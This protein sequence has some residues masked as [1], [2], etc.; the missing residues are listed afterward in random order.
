M[1]QMPP[2]PGNVPE[3]RIILNESTAAVAAGNARGSIPIRE[4]TWTLLGVQT[5]LIQ[6]GNAIQE[7]DLDY[8]LTYP[9]VGGSEIAIRRQSVVMAG[10][11]PHILRIEE[12]PL[13]GPGELHLAVSINASITTSGILGDSRLQVSVALIRNQSDRLNP[14]ESSYLDEYEGGDLTEYDAGILDV[15]GAAL[16]GAR[17]GA[18][19]TGRG[20]SGLLSSAIAGAGIGV[21][22]HLMRNSNVPGSSGLALDALDET[23]ND[24]APGQMDFDR[25]TQEIRMWNGDEWVQSPQPVEVGSGIQGDL[26]SDTSVMFHNDPR[27]VRLAD[28]RSHRFYDS[29]RCDWAEGYGFCPQ[30]RQTEIK[31]LFSSIEGGRRWTNMAAVGMLPYDQVFRINAIGLSLAFSSEELYGIAFRDLRME[32]ILGDRPVWDAQAMDYLDVAMAEDDPVDPELGFSRSIELGRPIAIGARM[33]FNVTLD[34]GPSLIAKLRQGENYLNA[35]N[36]EPV[37]TPNP[38]DGWFA[39]IRVSLIGEH[40][41]DAI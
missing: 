29:Y 32:L 24:P 9:G 19:N 15:F 3:L 2:V 17:Q 12:P 38:F 34:C 27:Q 11:S 6:E 28:R 40:R 25:T 13:E 16:S 35:R 8:V 20:G 37:G 7:M 33:G 26:G 1:A 5:H 22:T 18:E 39:L 4:G 30:Y 21:L 14:L 23:P 31:R 41:R 10:E 36:H